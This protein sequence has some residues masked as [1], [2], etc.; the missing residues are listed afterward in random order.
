LNGNRAPAVSDLYE[1]FADHYIAD[2][3][4]TSWNEERWLDRFL[5]SM[6]AERRILDLGCGAGAP[7]GK[8]LL[9]H[10]CSITGIDTSPTLINHC[11][12]HSPQGQWLVADMRRLSLATKFDGLIAWDSF[13]HLNHADQRDMFPVFREHAEPAALLLF[14]SGTEHGEAIG[15]Y[16]GEP[17][18][19]ASLAPAEYESLL[20]ENG[21]KVVAYVPE[22]PACG[23]HTIWL[24]RHTS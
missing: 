23:E 8:Y 4:R 18:Y 13:F 5:D 11:R 1:R 20:A 16:H 24:A 15:E 9:E 14:T 22:D 21:F 12:E 10:G 3:S 7:I 6:P 19:H 2:R 17:L